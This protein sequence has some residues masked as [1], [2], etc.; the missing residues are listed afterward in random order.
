MTS[1]FYKIDIDASCQWNKCG[2]SIS[3]LWLE[4]TIFYFLTIHFFYLCIVV[5]NWVI[6]ILYSSFI[7][8]LECCF[9]T[10]FLKRM[11][12]L[13]THDLTILRNWHRVHSCQ[14]NICYFEIIDFLKTK[15]FCYY[16][17]LFS[18]K[19]LL[20]YLCWLSTSGFKCRR[21]N[22]FSLARPM[23]EIVHQYVIY[24]NEDSRPLLITYM[25]RDTYNLFRWILDSSLLIGT[26][27]ILSNQG[28]NLTFFST[29]KK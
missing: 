9:F 22:I 6:F 21:P 27:K 24:R 3:W 12:C 28:S 29:R 8:P 16:W 11:L 17:N 19:Y 15:Q 14:W 1:R 7:F 18:R 2:F 13:F 5:L 10:H 26:V 23:R 25:S 4:N 20:S